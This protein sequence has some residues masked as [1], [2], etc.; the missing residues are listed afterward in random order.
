MKK[1]KGA[2]PMDMPLAE[3]QKHLGTLR[4]HGMNATLEPRL[5]ERGRDK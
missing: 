5:I 4:L 2:K 3:I 1:K